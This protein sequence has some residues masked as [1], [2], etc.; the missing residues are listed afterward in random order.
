MSSSAQRAPQRG[1][2]TVAMVMSVS[3]ASRGLFCVLLSLPETKVRPRQAAQKS[4]QPAH[5]AKPTAFLLFLMLYVDLYR[6]TSGTS[7]STPRAAHDESLHR[8][9]E[10]GRTQQ[11]RTEDVIR[12]S[13]RCRSPLSHTIYLSRAHTI[14]YPA[15]YTC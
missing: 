6:A 9:S 11:Q 8:V 7:C 15:D 2:I 12:A 5:F 10:L 4:H 1:W 3:Q 13:Q 14:R